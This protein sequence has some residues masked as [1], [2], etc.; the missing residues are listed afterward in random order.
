MVAGLG[1]LAFYLASSFP[2][3]SEEKK[4]AEP[5]SGLSL[6]NGFCATVFADNVGHARQLEVAQRTAPF[7]LTLGAA[8]IT[9][10]THHLPEDF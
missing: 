5:D 9:A 8:S 1:S 6:P 7:T 4:C 2:L 3:I 10:T